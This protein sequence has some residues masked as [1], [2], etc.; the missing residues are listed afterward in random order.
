MSFLDRF[1]GP[2]YEK[3][4]QALQPIVDTIN[5]L[6]SQY[7][8][9]DDADLVTTVQALKSKHTQGATLDSILPEMAALT[10][11]ASK[12]TLGLRHYDVQLLGGIL[13]HQGKITE[14]RTGEGKNP[15]RDHPS[16]SERPYRRRCARGDCQ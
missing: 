9:I 14:M 13:L 7:E 11:E 1:F 2:S 16:G 8:S 4:L 3:E 15:G 12:R 10:R 6:E 5:N